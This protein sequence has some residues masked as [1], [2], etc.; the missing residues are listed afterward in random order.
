MPS[1]SFPSSVFA[2]LFL[3]GRPDEVAGPGPPAAR[4]PEHPRRRP[5]P[6]EDA[7]AGARRR[8]PREAGRVLHQRPRAGAAAGQAEEWSKK[9]KPKVDAKPPQNIPNSADLI[10]KTRLMFDLIH[11]A[12]QTDSTRLVTLLLLGTSSVPPIPGVIAGPSRPVAPRPG[13]GQDRAAQDARA[14]EDEDAARLPRQAEADEGRR[15]D[16][17]RPDDGVLQQQPG[18]RQQPLDARTCR[19]CWPAA[20]SS[21][22][23]TWPSTRRTRRRCRNLYVSMLQRLGIEAD[24][25]GSSTGT[26]TGLEITG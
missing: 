16:A 4:R 10:G 3:E 18:Q 14:G 17:A 22:A 12:L 9:P 20:A 19:C 24:K 23:S 7:A 25:F 15:R 1:D 5:R 21:T 26:L 8:R 13:P 2:R 11:L 6:G